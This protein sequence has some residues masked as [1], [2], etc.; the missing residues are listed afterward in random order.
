MELI[1]GRGIVGRRNYRE[2]MILRL[3]GNRGMT[4]ATKYNPVSITN[5]Y[6]YYYF[7]KIDIKQKK[8]KFFLSRSRTVL[9]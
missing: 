7:N 3:R 1:R 4:L 2:S 9:N 8:L 5:Y 6:N